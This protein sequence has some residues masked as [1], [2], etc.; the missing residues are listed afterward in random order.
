[1]GIKYVL[2]GDNPYLNYVLLNR[3][4]TLPFYLKEDNYDKIKK[5]INNINIHYATFDDMLDNKYDFMN[6]SDI[7]EYMPEDTMEKYSKKINEC[8]NINGRVCYW[9]MMNTRTRTLTRINDLKDLERDRALYYK[10][11][12]VYQK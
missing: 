7:F 1:M 8:L 4:R 9:N 3:Y 2:N 5:N 12:L 6:L 11:F 10:D